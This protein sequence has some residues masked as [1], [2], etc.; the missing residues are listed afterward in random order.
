MDSGTVLSR[1]VAIVEPEVGE[2]V[3]VVQ[4]GTDDE[5]V[6]AGS[7]MMVDVEVGGNVELVVEVVDCSQQRMA[8][9]FSLVDGALPIQRLL[10]LLR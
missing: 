2:G 6:V 1:F 7:V 8:V 10:H 9:V 5:V 4:F 3:A